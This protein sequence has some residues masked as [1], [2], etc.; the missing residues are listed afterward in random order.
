[1]SKP[2]N[3]VEPNDD[4]PT[5]EELL[6]NG[7]KLLVTMALKEIAAKSYQEYLATTHWQKRRCEYKSR[8]GFRCELALDHQG[9]LDVHHVRY[10]NLGCEP[11]EDLILLCRNCHR[12]WHDTGMIQFREHMRNS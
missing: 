6:A 8:A 1:M 12:K 3:R 4:Y 11:D 7:G 10:D 2:P 9:Q 5:L